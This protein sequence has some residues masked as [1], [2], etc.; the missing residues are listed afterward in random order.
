MLVLSRKAGERILIGDD[1]KAAGLGSGSRWARGPVA[2]GSIHLPTGRDLRALRPESSGKPGRL[3]IAP[4][5]P[6]RVRC[7]GRAEDICGV[8]RL[9][10][11]ARHRGRCLAS[12][13]WPNGEDQGERL[14]HET[15]CVNDQPRLRV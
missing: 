11:R 15:W 6:A 5:D 2:Q 13:R 12:S 4:V 1:R 9:V 3:G 14:W 8:E 10:Y 7:R